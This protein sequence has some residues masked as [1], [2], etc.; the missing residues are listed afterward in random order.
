M[1]EDGFCDPKDVDTLMTQ[2]LGLR[3]SFIGPF[4][5]IHLNAPQGVRDYAARYSEGIV[6]VSEQFGAPRPMT[7]ETLD[8]VTEYLEEE[9]PLSAHSANLQWRDGVLKQLAVFKNNLP[10]KPQE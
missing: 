2:G 5:T 8:K 9:V 3:W 1:V 7:G 6:R 4:Q 10:P